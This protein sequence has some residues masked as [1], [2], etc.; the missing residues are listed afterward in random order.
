MIGREEVSGGTDHLR[1]VSSVDDALNILIGRPITAAEAD[2][3]TWYSELASSL[4]ICRQS[5][6][7]S[8]TDI[9]EHLGTTQSEVS[10]LERGVSTGT[11][12]GRLKSYV[13]SCGGRFYCAIENSEGTIVFGQPTV[14]ENSKPPLNTE[15]PFARRFLSVADVVHFRDLLVC[16]DE[17]L[18]RVGLAREQRDEILTQSLGRFQ[19]KTSAGKTYASIDASA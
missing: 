12:V 7:K 3:A 5:A 8:Q 9:A 2:E 19:G 11:S 18:N 16:I 15:S 6:G 13:E 10:R 17:E 4:R 1:K 14:E